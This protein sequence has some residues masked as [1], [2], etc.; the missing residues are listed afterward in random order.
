MRTIVS[1]G[2]SDRCDD[3][4]IDTID[5]DWK[6]LNSWLA[7][8]FKAY[9]V[10]VSIRNRNRLE[11]SIGVA[12]SLEAGKRPRGI[13]FNTAEEF[14]A[15]F[16]HTPPSLYLFWPDREPWAQSTIPV[17]DSVKTE[18]VVEIDPAIIGYPIR[19]EHYVYLEFR[20]SDADEYCRSV[21]VGDSWDSKCA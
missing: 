6:N 8:A 14:E 17:S 20:Q 5:N 13:D 16:I 7:G 9:E 4:H 2:G 11:Y 21:F 15:Q 18:I 19:A 1:D 12:F 3:L 10:A